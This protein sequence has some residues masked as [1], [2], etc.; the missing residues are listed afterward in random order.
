VSLSWTALSLGLS[1]LPEASNVVEK[2]GSGWIVR[3]KERRAGQKGRREGE[4]AALR[5]KY[6]KQ[7]TRELDGW[8]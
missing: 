1:E 3:D 7:I 2:S 5:L 8:L 4:R 6:Y